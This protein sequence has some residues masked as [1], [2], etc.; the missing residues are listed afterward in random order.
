M[1]FGAAALREMNAQLDSSGPRLTSNPMGQRVAQSYQG[2]TNSVIAVDL[3]K[4]IGLIP[5]NKP[6]DRENLEKTGFADVKYLVTENK[7]E[8]GRSANQMELAFNGPRRGIASW[9]AAP[10]PMGG[11]DF[12]SSKAAIAGDLMLKNPVQIF[13]DL[14]EIVGRGPLANLPEMEAQLNV[15]LKQDLLSKLG[16]EI[17]FEVQMPPMKV[18]GAGN[19][20]AP[21]GPGAFKLV[22][23]VLDPAGLQQ[24]LTRLLVMAPMQSGTREEDGVTFNTLS[25][26]S[27]S[28]QPTQINYF[29]MDGYLVIASDAATATEAVRAHRTGD[30]LGKSS[31]LRESLAKGQS[32]NASMMFYQNAGQ[33]MGPM[34]AQL[35]PEIRQLLPNTSPLDTKANVFYV[36]GEES[37]FRGTTSDNINTDVSIGLIVAAVAIPNL[38]RSRIAANEAA[39]A[40]SV[41]TVNTAQVTYQVTY[42]RRGYARNL[43]ALGPPPGGDC[44][45]NNVTPAHACLLDEALGNSTCTAGN[46]CTKGAYRYSVGGTCT[47]VSCSSYVVTATPVSADTGKKS[48]CSTADAVIRVHTGTPLELP[49]TAAQCK[50]WTPI[51]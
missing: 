21:Q 41:R 27:A 7:I 15:N 22:F 10:A 50:A 33:M 1:G 9:I 32:A 17:A 5:Q 49:L 2:G 12:V 25:S 45:D 26:P 4:V 48:F 44:S 14:V 13:D 34:F 18:S 38:L 28:G 8:G 23:R 47:Q 51:H 11:L 20:P 36:Y 30:S 29:F 40:S 19:S 37:A 39:A 43:A 6:Q 16:G 46:W 42:P 24:T 3:H 31:K 35:P